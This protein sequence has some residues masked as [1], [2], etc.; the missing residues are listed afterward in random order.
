M[1]LWGM[2]S[3]PDQITNLQRFDTVVTLEDHL[4]DGGFGSWLME[5]V[6]ESPSL[7][8][9]VI[10]KALTKDVCSTVGSQSTLNILGKLQP[11]I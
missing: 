4:I 9:R 3:K 8:G 11:D 7:A 1:P 2:S 5:S 10:P 6:S